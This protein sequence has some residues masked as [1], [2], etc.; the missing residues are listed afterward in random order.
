[1]DE[2]TTAAF[3]QVKT[4]KTAEKRLKDLVD[5][6]LLSD[7]AAMTQWGR[8]LKKWRPY[9]LN[10]FDNQ[11]T[12]AYTEGLHTKIKMIKRISFGFRNVD[13]YVRKVLLSL[14]PLALSS[15]YPTI[16]HRALTFLTHSIYFDSLFLDGH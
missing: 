13:A 10:F 11:T 5:I 3:L 16:C 7:G 1:M 2:G 14:F 4:K 8:T 12:N 15:L 6:A 9:V